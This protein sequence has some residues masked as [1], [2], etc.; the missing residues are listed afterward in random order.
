M[1]DNSLTRGDLL[2]A[3]PYLTDPNFRRSVVVLCEH[4]DDG[5]LGLVVNRP[6]QVP[7]GK[8]LDPLSTSPAATE[9]VHQGG[10]VETGRLLGIR[11]GSHPDEPG[12]S[13]GE[14]ISLLTDL[15][16]SLEL[17]GAGAVPPADYR[18]YLGYSGWGKGQLAHE[19]NESAWIVAPATAS[20]EL[21]F[22]VPAAEL[23]SRSLRAL[24]GSYAWFAEMP[25]DPEW[26]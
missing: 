21:T 14:G 20:A 2:I 9:L 10:P 25:I 26:N 3:S 1:S 12:E 15:E 13:V 17:I 8:V 16:H 7:L 18:F 11:R 22:E 4:G 6:M 19:V 5:S 24:G 23:W